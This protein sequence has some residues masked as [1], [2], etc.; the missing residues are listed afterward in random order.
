MVESILLRSAVLLTALLSGAVTS[1]G[2]RAVQYSHWNGFDLTTK[3]R[4]DKLKEDLLEKKP[5]VVWMTPPCTTQRT[6][7]SQSR[8]KFHRIQMYILVFLWLVKQDWC[9]AIL[10]QMW[11]ST[12]LD[13]GG[14]FS[15]LKEQFRCRTLG[16]QWGS[17][18]D[19]T[20]SSK[21]WYFICSHRRWSDLL[22][23]RRCLHD[24]PHQPFGER[25]VAVHTAIG[26]KRLQKRS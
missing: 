18:A 26:S 24:H 6:Q 8:S 5:R 7:R 11:G 25:N 23:P 16:C 19:G 12:S 17:L 22:C 1:I 21:S 10:E 4:I 3:A 9:E 14:V 20:F 2:G 13:R 15:E